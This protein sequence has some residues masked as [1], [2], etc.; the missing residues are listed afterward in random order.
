MLMNHFSVTNFKI[1]KQSISYFTH[2]DLSKEAI[3]PGYIMKV[4]QLA[5]YSTT[6]FLK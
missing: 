4:V 2:L 5:I 3:S 1:M 6:V